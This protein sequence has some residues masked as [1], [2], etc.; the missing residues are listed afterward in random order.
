[1][2]RTGARVDPHLALAIGAATVVAAEAGYRTWTSDV[3]LLLEAAVAAGALLYAWR[4]QARLRLLPLLALTLALQVGIVVVH[5]SLDVAG[6]I[7]SRLVFRWQGN[8]LLRGDYP[9]SEYP[10]GAVALFGLEA[11]LGGGTTRVANAFLMVPFQLASV[12]GIWALRT[13]FAPWLAALVALWPLNSFS[14]EFKYDPAPTALLVLGLLAALRER[15]SLAGVLLALGALVKWTPGLAFLA[16]AIWLVA[17]RRTRAAAEHALAFGATLV[18]VYVPVLVLAWSDAVAAYTRQGGRRISPESV[19]YLFL[20]PLGLAEVVDHIS[21]P[22][23]APDWA[24]AGAAAVQVTLVALL[25]LMAARVAGDLRAGVAVAA[26]V[27][28]VFLLTNRIFSPQFLVTL[29]AAWA[30]AAALVARSRGEQLALG[31]A[32]AGA[33]LANAFVYPFALPHYDVTWPICSAVLFGLGL[34]AS[35]WLV[36]LALLRSSLDAAIELDAARTGRV[37]GGSAPRPT[38]RPP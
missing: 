18:V 9:R 4:E 6:D 25:L 36:R 28:C 2:G 16:L 3:W 32:G 37:S 15:W 34:A 20:R 10:V 5:L 30:V 7:D 23:G 22:A 29:L 17:A 31:A 12:A 26:V 21:R 35:G 1:M 33:S 38:P 8:G 14:W 27:P 24:N 11:W 19:W 13:R